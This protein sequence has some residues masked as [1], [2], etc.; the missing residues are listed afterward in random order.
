MADFSQVN[1]K[2][3]RLSIQMPTLTRFALKHGYAGHVG[4]GL[5]VESNIHVVDLARAYLVLLHYMEQASS[6]EFVENPYFFCETTGDNEPSWRE[7][8]SAIGEGLHEAGK[9]ADPEPR[10]FP[11][12]SYGQLFSDFT[13][14]IVG[15][16][17][18]SRAIRLRE[19]GW[20]PVEKDWKRSLVEDELPAILKEDNSNFQGYAH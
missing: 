6:A 3:A 8:A 16:N 4:K 14:A 15:L 11:K 20:K 7:V 19:I 13:D 9:I 2:D 1:S 12:E 17:S 10:E 18:R 5:S